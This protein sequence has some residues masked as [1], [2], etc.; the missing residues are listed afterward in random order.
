MVL[1]SSMMLVSRTAHL[2]NGLVEL[3]VVLLRDIR[4]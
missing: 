2:G 3:V 4:C 1:V